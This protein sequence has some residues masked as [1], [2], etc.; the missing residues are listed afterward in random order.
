MHRPKSWYTN[1]DP[2]QYGPFALVTGAS[3]GIGRAC[4]VALAAAGFNLVLV[5]RRADPLNELS[6]QLAAEHGITAR[7]YS[8]DLSQPEAITA[9]CDQT[10]D[11]DIGLVVA[12][13]GFG[14]AGPFLEQDRETELAMIDLNCRAVADLVHRFGERMAGR[15]RGGIIL[16]GSLVGWQ[17]VPNSAT[18]A[19]TKAFVQSFAEGL[20]HELSPLGIHVL[21]AAPGPV[22]SGFASRARM[23]LGAT[24]TPEVVARSA[25][26]ALG[27]R[28]TVVP[29]LL[30]WLLT[31]SLSL[32]PRRVRT[33]IMGQ[34]MRT[35]AKRYGI[36]DS[37][38][39]QKPAG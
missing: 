30:G 1:P 27:R 38:A 7:V 28:Q 37:R 5:A 8:G 12:A 29:G 36:Q 2:K 16:F 11:L 33:A 39:Q 32:L 22:A 26:A 21:S 25:L 13:A 18:Y 35:M 19:A 20:H 9:L 23:Q 14:S 31:W 15:G 3:N 6:A 24:D 34:I 4:A 10:D 17:G